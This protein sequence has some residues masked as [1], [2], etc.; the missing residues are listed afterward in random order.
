MGSKTRSKGAQYVK[1]SLSD[2]G[3][4]RQDATG[5]NIT[6]QMS[7]GEPFGGYRSR[8]RWL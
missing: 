5:R 2:E 6:N 1:E 3:S 7:Q 8:V 4:D